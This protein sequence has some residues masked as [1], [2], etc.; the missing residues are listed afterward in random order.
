MSY[1]PDVQTTVAR[2]LDAWNEP[3]PDQRWALVH[4][5]VAPDA[6]Y[7]DP[8]VK[9]P[10]EGQP[11]LAAFIGMFRT[12]F[13]HRLEATGPIDGHHHYLRMPWRFAAGDDVM[14]TG[15]LVASLDRDR[16]LVQI[17]HFVD[18]ASGLDGV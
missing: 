7:T 12:Q 14:A 16:K 3:D 1:L 10:V 17:L 11:A 4:S 13:A 2:Y 5:A 18:P 8:G 9:D 15:L 6:V